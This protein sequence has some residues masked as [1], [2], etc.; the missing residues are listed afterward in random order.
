MMNVDLI[1]KVAGIGIVVAVLGLAV[2]FFGGLVSVNNVYYVTSVLN[3]S[4]SIPGAVST[5]G[6]W[7]GFIDIITGGAL[8]KELIRFIFVPLK[9]ERLPQYLKTAETIY[10]DFFKGKI[11]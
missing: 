7:N 3:A 2:A 4:Q 9:K 6:G 5:W 8:P 10:N 11:E 1:F